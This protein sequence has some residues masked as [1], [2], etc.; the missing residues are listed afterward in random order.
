MKTIL[1]SKKGFTLVEMLVVIAVL[2]I[3]GILIL[4]IFTRTLK[5]TNKS[6]IIS[7]IKQNGQSV[8]E[9]MDNNIRNSDNVAC[10]SLDNKIIVVDKR[11][12]YIRYTFIDPSSANGWIQQ[13][14]PVKGTDP[15]TD[16][17]EISV[18]FVNRVCANN[19][20]VVNPVSP[21]TLTDTNPQSG[22][23]VTNGIFKRDR[24]AGFRDSVKIA[25]E[26]DNGVGALTALA[27]EI[28]PVKFETTIVLR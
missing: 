21:V 5:G 18:V 8:L 13:D 9:N 1:N 22:V 11:G 17:E 19:D 24:L 27:Q 2:S 20:S 26:V 3:I 25:F 4:T 28:D 14:A 10:I 23:S 7:A 12:V 6:Q 15:S 16:E